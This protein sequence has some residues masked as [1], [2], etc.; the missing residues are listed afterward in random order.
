MFAREMEYYTRQ[1]KNSLSIVA[2][3]RVVPALPTSYWAK[4][5]RTRRTLRERLRENASSAAFS[6]PLAR[7]TPQFGVL[8]ARSVNEDKS[9]PIY[10]NL[11]GPVDHD[12]HD[13][14][15]GQLS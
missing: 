14:S 7:A 13:F 3:E 15:T 4:S 6:I 5:A 12:R 2:T 9:A 8:R 1:R 10:T 11:I